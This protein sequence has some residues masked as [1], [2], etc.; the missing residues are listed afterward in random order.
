MVSGVRPH[1]D[2]GRPADYRDVLAAQR[3]TYHQICSPLSVWKS[4]QISI[5]NG[6]YRESNQTC[7]YNDNDDDDDWKALA[8]Y[9]LATSSLC[10]TYVAPVWC[11]FDYESATSDCVLPRIILVLP[12][13]S[14]ECSLY[15]TQSLVR[16]KQIDFDI[17]DIHQQLLL[18]IK[19]K[20]REWESI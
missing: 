12:A 16:K 19:V 8:I 5:R 1:N 17:C 2:K 15:G 14:F 13:A 3:Q 6:I 7:R 9:S 18:F 20:R 10:C 11:V 4:V